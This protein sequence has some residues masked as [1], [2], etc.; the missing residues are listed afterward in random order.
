MVKI[1]PKQTDKT[2]NNSF[3]PFYLLPIGMQKLWCEIPNFFIDTRRLCFLRRQKIV[4]MTHL[5]KVVSVYFVMLGNF[6]KMMTI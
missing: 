3:Y 4:C 5:K 6:L 2:F 1:L